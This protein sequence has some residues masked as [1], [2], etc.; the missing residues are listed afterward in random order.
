MGRRSASAVVLALMMGLGVLLSACSQS[1]MVF[2]E[3]DNSANAP[4]MSN[5]KRETVF[6]NEG[7]FGSKNKGDQNG[8]GGGIGVNSF[9][10]RASL[11][12]LGFMP[13]ANADPF[14]GTILT[15]WYQLPETPAERYKLNVF[16]IDRALRSD[17]VRVTVFK[18]M[19]D[20]SGAWVDTKVD[21]KMAGDIENSILTRARQLRLVSE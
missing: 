6:G 10:W 4:R 2:P 19:R 11:D 15:D 14:G 1:E 17:G 21:P 7:M 13:I 16:I 12:T 18:Q 5:E 8:G 9:L 3:R 20:A